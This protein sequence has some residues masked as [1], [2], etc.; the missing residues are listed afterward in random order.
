MAGVLEQLQRDGLAVAGVVVINKFEWVQSGVHRTI[1][2]SSTVTSSIAITASAMRV[3]SD[4][5]CHI[6]IGSTVTAN[7]SAALLPANEIEIMPWNSSTKISTIVKT[8]QA[9]GTLYLSEMT[10]VLTD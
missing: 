3:V 4:T 1:A 10:K 7:S 2:I 8:G 9:T 5:P 6:D